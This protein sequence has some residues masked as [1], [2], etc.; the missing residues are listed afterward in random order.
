[1][2][3]VNYQLLI[4]KWEKV[5]SKPG[6]V[7]LW[8]WGQRGAVIYLGRLL[9]D[10]SSGT[11]WWRNW[12]KTN[13]GS[14]DLAP[15][16]GLPS[17]Y[18]SILLVRSYRTFAPLPVRGDVSLHRRYVSVALSSRSPAL[19]VTQQVRSF[20]SPDF[21]QTLLGSPQPPTPTFSHIWWYHEVPA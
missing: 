2:L 17:Q 6:S 20:G 4:I 19:G 10:A 11:F 12:E 1:L 7:P 15:N 5:G 21:P 3:I 8:F 9:P 14:F 13:R 18:L 16:R